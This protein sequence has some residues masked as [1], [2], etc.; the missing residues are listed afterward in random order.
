[1]AGSL[2]QLE[3][4]TG[5][6]DPSFADVTA[7]DSILATG[8]QGAPLFRVDGQDWLAPLRDRLRREGRGVAYHQVNT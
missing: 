8:P 7:R 2:V 6:P 3:S 1:V 4:T 5:E